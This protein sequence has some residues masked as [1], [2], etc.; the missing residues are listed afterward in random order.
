MWARRSSETSLFATISSCS[1]LR[2]HPALRRFVR[3]ANRQEK[4]LLI[5]AFWGMPPAGLEPATHG[6]EG[7]PGRPRPVC[8]P[9]QIDRDCWGFPDPSGRSATAHG[10]EDVRKMFGRAYGDQA[11]DPAARPRSGGAARARRLASPRSPAADC[12]RLAGGQLGEIPAVA[13]ASRRG[14]DRV[15]GG[16]RRAWKR[17]DRGEHRGGR[18]VGRAGRR[19]RSVDRA[20][21]LLTCQDP[22]GGRAADPSS[23]AT[24]VTLAPAHGRAPRSRSDRIRPPRVR[25]FASWSDRAFPA[26]SGTGG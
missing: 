21:W 4:V 1:H 2:L 12:A 14:L 15:A 5:V 18:V 3:D 11:Q 23:S 8:H 26:A 7:N 20:A 22:Q 10:G 24:S 16:T 6:L 13:P 9:W 25:A 19:G 17:R